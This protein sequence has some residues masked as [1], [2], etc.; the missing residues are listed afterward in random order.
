MDAVEKSVTISLNEDGDSIS[1]GDL[2]VKNTDKGYSGLQWIDISEEQ[3]Y[4]RL[5]S[6]TGIGIGDLS[7]DKEDD[8]KL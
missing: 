2:T 6:I 1:I 7:E 3:E 5:P 4:G 8:T